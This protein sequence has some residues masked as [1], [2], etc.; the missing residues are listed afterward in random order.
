MA[1]SRPTENLPTSGIELQM[2]P[3]EETDA[4]MCVDGVCSVP[5][6]EKD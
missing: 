4:G 3:G 2:L 1:E 6:A 5:V